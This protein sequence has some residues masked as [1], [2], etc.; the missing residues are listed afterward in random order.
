M[1]TL[2][3]HTL[4]PIYM[5]RSLLGLVAIVDF[6]CNAINHFLLLRRALDGHLTG[7]CRLDDYS[8]GCL[9]GHFFVL[10]LIS[11]QHSARGRAFSSLVI[12]LER[13]FN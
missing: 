12:V 8:E 3:A 9:L 1:Q 2:G 13:R 11:L 4:A 6:I 10:L 5:F 7:V